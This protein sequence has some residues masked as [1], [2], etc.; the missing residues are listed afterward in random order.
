MFHEMPK[1]LGISLLHERVFHVLCITAHSTHDLPGESV[2]RSQSNTLQLPVNIGSFR[3]CQ[4]VMSKSRYRPDTKIYSVRDQVKPESDL[5][6]RQRKYYGK[7]FTE[8]LYVSLERL[9]SGSNTNDPLIDQ[10]RW[11][12]M[13]KSNAMGST[14]LAPWSVQKKET[15][16]AVAKDVLYVLEQIRRQREAARRGPSNVVQ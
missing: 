14:R 10:H 8:G 7:K 13:T 15:L 16:E 4:A 11:D 6:A 5:S 2:S 3:D 9:F 1:I 12:M